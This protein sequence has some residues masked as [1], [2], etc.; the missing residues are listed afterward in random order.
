MLVLPTQSFL[1]LNKR[2][3]CFSEGL[4]HPFCSETNHLK[5][6]LRLYEDHTDRSSQCADAYP[7]HVILAFQ[8]YVRS[9]S[10]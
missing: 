8:N 10:S 5:W 9:E 2:R 3:I 4:N 6:H 7:D 1:K